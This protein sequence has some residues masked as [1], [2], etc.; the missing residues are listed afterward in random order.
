M[1][2]YS[3]FSDSLQKK[4][5]MQKVTPQIALDFELKKP[6]VFIID[7]LSNSPAAKAGLRK[8]N[9]IMNYCKN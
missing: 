6:G 3:I 2:N 7:I 4:L 5:T 9:I 1:A 8:G